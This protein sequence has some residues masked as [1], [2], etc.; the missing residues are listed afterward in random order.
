MGRW[1]RSPK[2]S[3]RWPLH[4]QRSKQPRGLICSFLFPIIVGEQY[5]KEIYSADKVFVARTTQNAVDSLARDKGNKALN[6][7]HIRSSPVKVLSA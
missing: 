6:A 5:K 4:V 1:G 3:K 2:V 7:F